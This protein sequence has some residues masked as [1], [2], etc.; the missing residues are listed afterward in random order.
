MSNGCKGMYSALSGRREL[1]GQDKEDGRCQWGWWAALSRVV[2]MSLIS[3]RD[4][5]KGIKGSGREPGGKHLPGRGDSQAESSRAGQEQQGGLR[6]G[7]GSTGGKAKLWGG[8]DHGDLRGTRRALALTQRQTG[9]P[10]RA[11]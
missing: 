11:E 10:W 4:S 3:K 1:G 8:D 6:W 7:G 9:S 5:S 2:S